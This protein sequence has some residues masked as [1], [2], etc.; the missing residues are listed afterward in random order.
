MQRYEKAVEYF[1]K[2][3]EVDSL[4][5]AFYQHLMVCYGQ[6][7]RKAEAMAVYNRCCDALS[8]TLGANPSP[9]TEAIY[10]S[11]RRSRGAA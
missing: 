11:L 7:G 2:G 10:S 5:E 3:L 9:A 8:S 4:A 6:L 1:Q